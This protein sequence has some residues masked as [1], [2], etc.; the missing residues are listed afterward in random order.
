MT[1]SLAERIR[2]AA[3]G[4]RGSLTEN[5]DLSKITWFRVGGPAEAL[6]MPADEEDLALVLSA[7]DETVPV[8]VLGLGSNLLVRDGGIPG[9]VIRLSGRGFGRLKSLKM[10]STPY[11]WAR[12]CRI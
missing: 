2:H 9:L 5:A 11:M 1:L 3:P 4:I 6:F 10:M 7:L 8:M 12:L